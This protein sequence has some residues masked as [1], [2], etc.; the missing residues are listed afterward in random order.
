M[1]VLL[2]P[3]LA[4]LVLVSVVLLIPG[5]APLRSFLLPVFSQLGAPSYA[6]L[7][8]ASALLLS[9]A[10]SYSSYH[11]LTAT[12]VSRSGTEYLSHTARQAEAERDCVLSVSVLLLVCLVVRLCGL[13]KD[14]ASLQA[15]YTAMEKQAKGASA[16]Y[17]SQLGTAGPPSAPAPASS[18]SASSAS[19]QAQVASLTAERAVMEKK[20]QA[21]ERQARS[22]S[23][24]FLASDSA[25][26]GD[27]SQ[28]LEAAKAELRQL[29]QDNARLKE[30]LEDYEI[31]MGDARKKKM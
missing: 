5:L 14:A 11:A 6:L 3:L 7:A 27:A 9:S 12:A 8:V 13:L 4:A 19:L 10:L 21:M 15:R 22:A 1:S 2:Y 17:M 18:S 30:Q 29:R 31:V 24:A 23:E 16:A 26:S 25:R 28:Q 20:L